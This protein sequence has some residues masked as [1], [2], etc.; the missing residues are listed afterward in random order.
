MLFPRVIPWTV[1]SMFDS[2]NV[3]TSPSVNW[4]SVKYA[5]STFSPSTLVINCATA[6]LS[7]P[8]IF[9][10][11]MVLVFK[12]SP[13]TVVILSKVGSLLFLDSKT[14]TIFT[15]SGAFKDISLSSILKP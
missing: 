12:E 4:V 13:D 7:E 2:W 1:V 8:I 11:S 5:T 3:I 14:E 15:T 9:S 6:P 10:P